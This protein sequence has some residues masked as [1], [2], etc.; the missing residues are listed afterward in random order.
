MIFNVLKVQE[1][2]WHRLDEYGLVLLVRAGDRFVNGDLVER[3]EERK[4]AA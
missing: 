2:R 4:D 1:G 3:S